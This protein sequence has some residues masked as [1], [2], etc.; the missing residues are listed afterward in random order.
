M[1][2]PTC[3]LPNLLPMFP[4][5]RAAHLAGEAVP[6]DVG[7]TLD[8]GESEICCSLAV[9]ILLEDGSRPSC[10]YSVF[11]RRLTAVDKQLLPGDR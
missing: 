11:G 10:S 5:N 1:A 8:F 4:R 9:I 7:T 3:I 2:S 6:S